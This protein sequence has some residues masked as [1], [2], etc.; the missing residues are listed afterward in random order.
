MSSA[1]SVALPEE[2]FREVSH[3]ATQTGVSEQ[4][5]VAR[6][7]E[8]RFRLEQQTAE[9]FRKRASQA[10]SKTLG[11]LLDRAPDSPPDPGDEFES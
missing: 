11:E 7:L 5:Y 3:H 2:L 4:E 6:V 1:N 9:F 8:E 10:S